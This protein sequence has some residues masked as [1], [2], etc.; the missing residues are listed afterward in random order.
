MA[1]WEQFA[2][3]ATRAT[4]GITSEALRLDRWSHD[5]FFEAST[6]V[7]G[8]EFG[9][10]LQSAPTEIETAASVIVIG[11]LVVRCDEAL[12]EVEALPK[13]GDTIVRLERPRQDELRVADVARDGF[14][15]LL[16][17]TT[18]AV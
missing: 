17:R 9:G 3:L 7:S 12:F 15:R 6:P 8:F 10:S 16:I 5:E 18:G 2:R 11:S 14:G 1:A 13:P 4:D